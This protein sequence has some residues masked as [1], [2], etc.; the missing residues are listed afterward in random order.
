MFLLAEYAFLMSR[1]CI[2][3]KQ[4]VCFVISGLCIFN[5]QGMYFL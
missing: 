4:S 3:D 2:F 5:K 1:I